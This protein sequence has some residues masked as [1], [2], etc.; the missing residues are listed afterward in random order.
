MSALSRMARAWLRLRQGLHALTALAQPVALDVAAATLTSPQFALFCRL[1]RAEQLH[2]LRV[3]ARVQAQAPLT[4][5]ALAR[6][7]LLH[8]VGKALYPTNTLQKTITVLLRA[9]RPAAAAHLAHGDPR[10]PLARPFVVRAQHP[11][12]GA[13]ALRDAASPA[14]DDDVCLLWLVEHHADAPDDWQAQPHPYAALLR[15]LQL[16]DDAE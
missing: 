10:N 7:A 8:D 14:D 3:L 15:R 9:V 13:A 16:A 6:A 5:L 1:R 12:W 4:P 2:S 11:A